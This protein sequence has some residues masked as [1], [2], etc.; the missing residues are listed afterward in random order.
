MAGLSSAGRGIAGVTTGVD[1]VSVERIE[2]LIARWGD[3]FLRRVYTEGEIAYAASK[4]FPA[5]SF[6]A[7]FAAKE[8]FYKAVSPWCGEPIGH[9][10]IEVIV[11][12]GGVPAI[13]PHGNARKALGDRAAS[14]SLSHERD[15]AVAVVVASPCCGA[16]RPA[17]RRRDPG[18]APGKRAARAPGKD[19]QRGPQP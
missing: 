5:L 16:G 4:V 3:R 1:L 17:R 15:L 12:E 8:A 2:R 11:G 6:A 14:L 7:R 10:S 18:D 9:K 13:R 19:P